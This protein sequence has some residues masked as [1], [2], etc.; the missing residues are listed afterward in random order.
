MLCLE[1]TDAAIW[2]SSDSTL[3]FGFEIAKANM[4]EDELPDIGTH[5]I[6]TF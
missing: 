3:K 2:G 5:M 1:L 6:L 4:K